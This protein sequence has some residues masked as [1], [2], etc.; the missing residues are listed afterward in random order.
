MC[1]SSVRD[2]YVAKHLQSFNLLNLNHNCIKQMA[3]QSRYHLW[4][5]PKTF[6]RIMWDAS[7]TQL[8]HLILAY[9]NFRTFLLN[10]RQEMVGDTNFS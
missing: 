10:F 5:M 3:T 8:K 6:L 9:G 2:R 7:K 4:A 1:Q